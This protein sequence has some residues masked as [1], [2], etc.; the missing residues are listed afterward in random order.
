MKEPPPQRPEFV[1]HLQDQADKGEGSNVHLEA[2]VNP[3][4]DHTMRIEWYKDGRPITASSRIATMFSF[5]HVSLHVSGLRAEDAG[6][7]VCRAVNAAGEAVSQCTV[8]VRVTQDLTD[9]T[10]IMEQRQ[11]IEKTE[12]LERQQQS[13]AQGTLLNRTESVVEPTQPPEF[14]TPIKDQLGIREGAFAHF[15]ARLEPMGDH[16]MKVEWYKDGRLVDASSRIST[17]FNFGYVALTIKQVNQHD[18]GTYSCVA[19]NKCGRADTSAKMTTLSAADAD[20]QS[21]SWSSIQQLE[22]SK[23]VGNK[24]DSQHSCFSACTICSCSWVELT[25]I[26][27]VTPSCLG[28]STTS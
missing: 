22:M 25:D 21:K 16:T 7:Y 4:S 20:F 2:Q 5:G 19:F 10:G 15:E 18:A 24:I 8:S 9:S 27:H 11:Y 3:I 28:T 14:K 26:W 12:M 17:F 13:K 6:T 23:Q 1:R